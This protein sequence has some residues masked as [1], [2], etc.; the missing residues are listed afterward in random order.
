MTPYD[1]HDPMGVRTP[2][3]I[4]HPWGRTRVCRTPKGG[5]RGPKQGNLGCTHPLGWDSVQGRNTDFEIFT[6]RHVV[7]STTPGNEKSPYRRISLVTPIFFH[8]FWPKG[9][10]GTFSGAENPG[11]PPPPPPN[12]AELTKIPDIHV[13]PPN[14]NQGTL[15]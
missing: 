4:V 7:V 10:P 8:F 5:Q 12:Q 2:L 15:G 14:P 9:Y 6:A 3:P 1:S 11:P 13:V